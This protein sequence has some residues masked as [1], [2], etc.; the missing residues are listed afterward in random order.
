VRVCV[1]PGKTYINAS[2]ELLK[3]H[4]QR[5][6]HRH[7]LRHVRADQIVPG[8]SKV[9]PSGVPSGERSKPRKDVFTFSLATRRSR[10]PGLF[11]VP[12]TSYARILTHNT[13]TSCL[14]ES[15]GISITMWLNPLTGN[16]ARK[17]IQKYSYRP[18]TSRNPKGK[19]PKVG[20]WL[21]RA[22]NC[23]INTIVNITS[24]AFESGVSDSTI[25]SIPGVKFFSPVD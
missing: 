19:F 5:D 6:H 11:P 21:Q 20:G 1:V 4:H 17:S 7:H 9:I 3:T 22:Y 8:E 10:F 16:G 15:N 13:R 23:N 12:G 2:I 25:S 14:P 18:L 24:A